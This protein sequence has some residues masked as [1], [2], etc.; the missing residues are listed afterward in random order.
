LD[1]LF[2][3]N[4]LRQRLVG[5]CIGMA[6]ASGG[7]SHFIRTTIPDVRSTQATL[8][9]ASMKKAFTAPKLT[10]ER[11]LAS[12]TLGEPEPIISGQFS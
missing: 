2:G 8:V 12:L 3:I 4:G 6:F 7:R 11:S 5:L 1:N 10:A 9:E